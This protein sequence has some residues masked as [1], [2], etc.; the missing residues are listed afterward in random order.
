MK[1]LYYAGLALLVAAGCEDK[2]DIDLVAR[3]AVFVMT[4]ASTNAIVIFQRASNGA[5]TR[6][7]TIATGGSGLGADLQSQ[8]SLLLSDDGRFLFAANAGSDD[9][10]VF[11]LS[12]D[13]LIAVQRIGSGGDRPVS[14]ANNGNLVY[15][16]NAGSRNIVGFTLG[17]NGELSALNVSRN[18]SGNTQGAP[19]AAV[20]FS[21]DGRLLAVSEPGADV[22]DIF[23]VDA[24]GVAGQAISQPSIADG[25]FGLA[26]TPSNQLI[27][28]N[29]GFDSNFDGIVTAFNVSAAGALSFADSIRTNQKETKQLIVRNNGSFGYASNRGSNSISAFSI[30]GNGPLLLLNANGIA[31]TTGANPE[32]LDLTAGEQFLYVLNTGDDTISSFRVNS[33]GSLTAIATAANSLPETSYGLQAR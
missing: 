5:L 30:A 7:R 24:N 21:R 19:P 2:S 10:T 4:N 3:P 26:F 13:S 28:G 15:V 20:E 17:L 31:A 6:G 14:I 33:D 32:D 12:S 29:A 11:R 18:L 25:P 16:L 22:L 23:V 8:H 27:V 9:I 1:T